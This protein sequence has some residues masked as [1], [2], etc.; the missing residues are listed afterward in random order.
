MH[1]ESY[2]EFDLDRAFYELKKG[3]ASRTKFIKELDEFKEGLSR[4]IGCYVFCLKHG[5]KITPWYVGKT[6]K[7]FALE[8]LHDRK[9]DKYGEAIR[10]NKRHIPCMLFFPKMTPKDKFSKTENKQNL[11][12]D[13]LETNLISIAL[14]KNTD[15]INTSKTR[16]VR[17]IYVRGILG[18]QQKGQPTDDIK[19]IKKIFGIK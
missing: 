9:L 7:S 5:V 12:I 2:G 10:D 13:W 18:V 11:E 17:D 19:K 16:M 3:K 15:L 6:T 1:F 14:K 8:A 4:A